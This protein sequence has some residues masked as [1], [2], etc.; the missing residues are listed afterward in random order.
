MLEYRY[1]DN[2]VLDNSI[3]DRKNILNNEYAISEI[4]ENL[5][6]KGTLFRGE[7]WLTTRQ[8]ES[9]FNIERRTLLRYTNDYRA[10]LEESGYKV[11][12]GDELKEFRYVGDTNVTNIVD[13]KVPRQ[14]IFNT[15]AFLNLAMLLAESPKARTLRRMMLEITTQTVNMLAG[16]NTK[17]INQRDEK[18][19]LAAYY[20]EGYNKRLRDALKNYVTDSRDTAK[21]PNYND[22]VYK[23]IFKENSKEYKTILEL[24]KKERPRDTMYADVLSAISSFENTIAAELKKAFR[25]KGNIPLT[26]GEVDEIF[27]RTAEHPAFEPQIETARR[28]MASLDHALRKKQ[29]NSLAGYIYPVD[30]KDFERFLGEKSKSLSD[31]IDENIDVLK[32][33]KDK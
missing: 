7:Y 31:R 33:L 10:E 25:E 22:K 11:I 21:Y 26:R 24:N 19:L 15:K 29:H 1:M 2:N 8:V 17:Y 20:N 28:S 9:Y 14:G 3:T 12:S 13:E 30:K 32:R 6:I 16:G 27:M 23:I 4:Q 5:D 18:Y